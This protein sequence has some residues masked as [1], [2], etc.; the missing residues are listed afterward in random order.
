MTHLSRRRFLTAIGAA[1]TWLAVRPFTA[2]GGILDKLFGHREVKPTPPITPN[3][4]F[5]VTSYRSPPTVRV[6]EWS[7]RILG[8]VERPLT[9]D[10]AQLLAKP[11]VSQIVT[12]ECVGNTVA[13]EYISTAEWEG[14]PLRALLDEA[15]VSPDAYDVVFRAAD[16][17]SDSIRLDRA[18]AGDVLLAHKMNGVPL[19]QGHGFPARMIVPGVYGMKSVQWLTE[20]EVVDQDYQ[21]Y[22]QQKGWSDEATIKTMSRIDVPGHG[23]TLHGLTHLV[24]GLAFAGTRGIRLVELSMDGGAQWH[25][26][27][28]TPPLSPSS[29]V[30][31]SFEWAVLNAGRYEL[32]VRATDGSGKLQTSIE[33]DPAPDGATGLHNITVTVDL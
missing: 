16:G 7:M 21:G 1:T 20:I 31:W 2:V 24:Q 15:G 8:L 19:P 3:E 26:A 18:M 5:Y 29:W 12:L 28:L 9:L 25:A 22:Y 10:Y 6:A 4:D 32:V 23:A 30:L 27:T 14:I 17:Y 13:D 11:T 33:Q